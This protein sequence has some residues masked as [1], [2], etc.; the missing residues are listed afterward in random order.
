[1]LGSVSV[2]DETVFCT[3]RLVTLADVEVLPALSVATARKLYVPLASALVS[4]EQEYGEAVTVHRS[5]Q[6][7]PVD[8]WMTTFAM[9]ECASLAV[10]V[11]VLVPCSGEPGSVIVTV[12]AR[13]STMTLLTTADG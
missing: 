12:G 3:L 6:A 9:P 7:P 2:T 8:D 4:T 13:L 1:V 11:K 5:A 10:A